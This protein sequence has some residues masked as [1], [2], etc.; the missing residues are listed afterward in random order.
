MDEEEMEE[1]VNGEEEEEEG[2][3]QISPLTLICIVFLYLVSQG[4]G[5]ILSISRMGGIW[6]MVPIIPL[7][8]NNIKQTGLEVRG[9]IPFFD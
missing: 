8:G 4:R 9:F 1:D 3:D 5:F 6:N 7:C 2:E